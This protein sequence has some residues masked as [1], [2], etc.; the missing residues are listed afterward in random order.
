MTQSLP[1]EW[2]EDGVTTS[3]SLHLSPVE[4][5]L[6]Q[7]RVIEARAGFEDWCKSPLSRRL[8]IVRSVR[9]TL[10]AGAES[11]SRE[12]CGERAPEEFLVSEIIPFLDACKFLQRNAGKLLRPKTFDRL[13]NPVW[14]RGVR[15]EVV[16]EPLGVV[17]IIAPSNYPFFLPGVQCLQ[18]ITAGNVVL[19][20]PAAGGEAAA[21]TLEALLDRAGLPGHVFQVL[22]SSPSA[23]T[24]ALTHSVD[25]VV[26]TGSFE[27]GRAV[28]AQAAKSVIPSVVEL[29]GCDGSLVYPDADFNLAAECI[30]FG[31]TLNSGHTCIAPRRV[32]VWREVA[33]RF[34]QALAGALARRPAVILRSNEHAAL[35]KTVID[36]VHGGAELL[37]GSVN[38]CLIHAPIVFSN[39]PPQS[40]L[41]LTENWGPVLSIVEVESEEEA[42]KLFNS[43]SFGL[44]AS[45][46]SRSE[47][48]AHAVARSLIAGSI[49][50]N[51]IIVPPA[52]GRVPFAGRKHSG[53]GAT[54]GGE[55]LLEMTALKVI[56]S[57]TGRAHFHLR[58]PSQL[59]PGQLKLLSAYSEFAYGRKMRG[60]VTMCS[61]LFRSRSR[62][63]SPNHKEI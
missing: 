59:L 10:A 30:A 13:W 47:I 23:A 20:K 39:V 63:S 9:L 54:R 22:P 52:D 43:S 6:V 11:T 44:G 28:L 24:E 31:L 35:G 55:G 3:S 57:R 21:R 53:F 27:T 36:A 29:S 40:P 33:D 42:L 38:D 4:S 50:I 17:L 8:A 7:K 14:L 1:I 51:D 25:K 12:L 5:T 18:A 48:R 49:C 58:P 19:L 62:N 46:F 61:A 37:H 15:H 41:T 2:I 56:S 26:L 32:F 34:R 45:I 60:F 16:R